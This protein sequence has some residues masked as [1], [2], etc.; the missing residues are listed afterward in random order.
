MSDEIKHPGGRPTKYK[1]EYAEQAYKLC[2]LGATNEELADFFH[3]A[4]STIHVWRDAYQEFSDAIQSAKDMADANVAESLYKRATGYVAPDVHVASYMGQSIVTPIEKHYPPD[5]AAAFIWLKNRQPEKW[6]DK[7]EVEHSGRLEIQE[8][9]LDDLES[10]INGG[11]AEV[12][13]SGE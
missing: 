4:V 10:A 7:K 12:P 2:L 3:V 9:T 1:P 8:V 11:D 5:T 13:E 6:R